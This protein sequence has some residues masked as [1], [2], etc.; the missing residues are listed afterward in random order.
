M[1]KYLL[2]LLAAVLILAAILLF[3][4]KDFPGW[5][6]PDILSSS[7]SRAIRDELIRAAEVCQGVKSADSLEE[8]LIGAG[9]A[10]VDSDAIYPSYLANADGVRDFAA[11]RS[12][13]SVL[14]A[15]KNG[16]FVHMFF[17][18]GDEDFLILTEVSQ[19]SQGSFYV[20]AC[21]T[22]PLYETE[23][24]D[25]DIFYYR[26]YP[27]NDPHYIDYNQLRLTPVDRELYDLTR[28]Y[29]LPVGYQMVNL[30]LCD[31]QEGNWGDLA[32]SD[33]FEYLYERNTG[34]P[35]PWQDFP[36]HPDS[37]YRLIPAQL[38]EDTVLP[39]FRVSREYL[40]KAC[41]Y[42]S[43]ADAYPWRPVHGDD[44]TTWEY[45]YREPQVTDCQENSDGTITLK[46]QV[47]SAEVKTNNLFSHEVTLR[48]FADGG[49]QYVANRIS[50]TSS[51][52]LP[53][54]MARFELD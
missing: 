15:G 53:P 26:L 8:R 47:Y 45:P 17:A 33:V 27:E 6:A 48:P 18:R 36:V 7:Q 42:D 28:E 25:W 49:F 37:H 31:W 10:T 21:E 46:V 5:E 38:F 20:S 43:A 24:A 9:F 44:L 35:L 16:G 1:K 34:D 41:Q 32:F 13:T 30:F 11:G 51:Y 19:H 2:L 54:A 12:S 14:Q 4:Q 50:Y 22:L 52:G 23:L 40:R 3:P 29:I 39:Y